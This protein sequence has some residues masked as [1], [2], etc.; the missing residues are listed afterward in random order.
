[1]VRVEVWLEEV[2]N[3]I[4]LSCVSANMS[5]RQ[6]IMLQ[7]HSK[8]MENRLDK[9]SH[10]CGG[11][12]SPYA[13]L[14]YHQAMVRFNSSLAGNAELRQRIDHLRQERNVFEGIQRQHQRVS[15]MSWC[16]YHMLNQPPNVEGLICLCMHYRVCCP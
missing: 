3:V 9:V 16:R 7:K 11:V 15:S 12:L 4:A 1:M 5:H 8:V 14:C 6:H 13:L 2:L 10:H